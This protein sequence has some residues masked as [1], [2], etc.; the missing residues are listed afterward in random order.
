MLKH[1]KAY[2]KHL[3][4]LCLLEGVNSLL[5]LAAAALLT[6]IIRLVLKEEVS[7][8]LPDGLFFMLFGIFALRQVL[9]YASHYIEQEI[10]NDFQARCRQKIHAEALCKGTSN[11][12]PAHLSTLAVEMCQA[13][14]E[15]FTV[16]LPECVQIILVL[17]I[18]LFAALALDPWTALLYAITLPLAPF[19]LYLIGHLTKERNEQQWQ[20]LQELSQGFQELL[21][22]M[23]SLKL[24][25]Q[26]RAQA[27][28]LTRLSQGFTETSLKVLQ[29]AF[30]SSF[31][32]ELLTTLAIAIVA[33][34]IGLRLL[35]G[36]LD[37]P[38][39]FFLLLITPLFYQ[40]VRQG[41][42][43]FHALIKA[44]T[45]EQQLKDFLKEKP[46][47]TGTH[48]QLQIPPAIFVKN[49]SFTYS[50]YSRPV[51]KNLTLAFP[52]GQATALTGPSGCGKST[53]LQIMAG[54]YLPSNETGGIY[55]ETA[56]IHKLDMA[57]RNKLISYLPQEPYI[58]SATVSEN[59]SL[60]QEVPPARIEQ[61]LR[62]ASLE[63]WFQR[64]PHG[65]ETKIGAGGL[66]L[67][68][69]EQ[70]CLGLARIILQNRPVVLLDEPT[71]G[72]D[73]ETEKSVLKALDAFCWQ[74]T[75]VIVTHRPAVLNWTK[76]V[77]RMAEGDL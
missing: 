13:L 30:A 73:E 77:V 76:Q 10:S 44:K 20:K 24:A 61:A 71:A 58:F 56:D 33:V 19:L 8:I 64:L 74:R 4:V 14:D 36:M 9:R 59:V 48:S 65:L 21:S 72:L 29:L 66:P 23:I 28:Y 52:A 15:Y 55:L 1:I 51:L 68:H 37:F 63:K 43:C 18:M 26:S 3:A 32:L 54:F 11:A 39:A 47:A 45:A 38:T 17:P 35:N 69:G 34:S 50:G 16:V 5:L 25:K 70:K 6:E 46:A 12:Q 2:S 53:L 42:A 62:L 7:G 60:F 67:S 27:H 22:G 57:S 40:P 41:G 49:L 75:L 31:M